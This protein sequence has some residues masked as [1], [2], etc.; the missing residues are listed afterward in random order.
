MSEN[1]K[2]HVDFSPEPGLSSK[3]LGSSPDNAVRIMCDT[4]YL[5]V[6]IAVPLSYTP[7][8]RISF[9]MKRGVGLSL[10]SLTI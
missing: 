1:G 3:V 2:E 7:A 6:L 5:L 4:K 10:C 8:Y 9:I